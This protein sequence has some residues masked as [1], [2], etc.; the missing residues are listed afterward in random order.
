M[1]VPEK[2][3]LRD[4]IHMPLVELAQHDDF[5]EEFFWMATKLYDLP[6]RDLSERIDIHLFMA[7]VGE[8]EKADENT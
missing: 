7:I 4:Y 2:L 5:E 3:R 6:M 8:N 1:V